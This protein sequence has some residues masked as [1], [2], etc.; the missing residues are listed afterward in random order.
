MYL[1]RVPLNPQRRGARR[2]LESPARLHATVL[3]GFETLPASD[4]GR[5]LWRLDRDDKHVLNLF[6]LSPDRPHY[7]NITEEAGW[8]DQSPWQ[9]GDYTPFL[10]RLALGQ[11]W[12][13]RLVANPIRNART[14]EGGRGKRVSVGSIYHQQDWLVSKSERW[15]FRIPDGL[16]GAPNLQLSDRSTWSFPRHSDGASRTVTLATVRFDGIL[17]VT[18]PNALRRTLTG[19]IGRAKAYGCG[20]LT[21]AR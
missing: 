12:A 8:G 16:S 5:I 10:D 4:V 6:V 2:L 1:T 17:Q 9:T 15:G 21:L 14:P 20:L 18:D 13:F 3:G 19:G 7:A 11:E